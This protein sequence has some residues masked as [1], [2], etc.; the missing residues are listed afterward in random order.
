M[1]KS[2]AQRALVVGAG[3]AGLTTAWWLERAGWDVLVVEKAPSFRAGGY[4]IDFFGPGHEVARRMGLLPALERRRAPISSVTSVDAR[5]RSR[6]T[7]SASAYS[8][9]A[10]GV[11]SLLRGELAEVILA[12]LRSPIRHGTTVSAVDDGL[13]TFS[14]GSADSFDLVVGA[15]GVHSR[16]RELVFGSSFVRYLGHH[17]AA[18][19]VQD[20]E[21][22][23]RIG[24]RY[25]MLT[26]PHRM[27]GCYAVRGGAMAALMLY[28]SDEQA[29]PA[30]PAAALRDRFGDLG[31]VA[32]ELLSAVPQDIYYDE[33]S[34]VDLPTWHR[35][36]VVLVG[37]ACGAVSLFAGHGASLAM[38]GAFVLAE[39][40]A[41]GT[42]GAF[43]RYQT[44]M[45]PAV[46]HTQEFGRRFIGWMAPSSTWRISL[47]DWAFRLSGLPVVRNLIRGSVA[48]DVDGVL[49]RAS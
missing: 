28:R 36:K 12:D 33:V 19:S 14:D 15:D 46:A 42:D 23:A 13:V 39:E 34:Q 40:L 26:V 27:I 41:A 3:I 22:S 11:I 38:T 17:T 21:L 30:D 20:P 48:P 47:R 29:V 35:G 18:F 2:S 10:D 1:P 37:D 44:R 5:G 9:V 8:A 45:K 24:Y 16:V 49:H 32:P 7:I 43:E 25:Q 6:A 31:W 4:M